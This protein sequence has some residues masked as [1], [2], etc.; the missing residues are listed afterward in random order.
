MCLSVTMQQ[1]WPR[2]LPAYLGISHRSG[3]AR[4]LSRGKIRSHKELRALD[5][6]TRSRCS[7][8]N[9]SANAKAFSRDANRF[10]PP[11]FFAIPKNRNNPVPRW[12]SIKRDFKKP[13]NRRPRRRVAARLGSRLWRR[14]RH[15]N[16]SRSVASS[17]LWVM[18]FWLG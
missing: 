2:S 17:L 10:S 5:H 13:Q 7:F 9:S 11:P 1:Y 12:F 6:Y 16:A 8:A 18:I 14:C 15:G 4:Q 3:H